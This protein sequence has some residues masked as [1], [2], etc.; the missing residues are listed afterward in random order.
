MSVQL[1]LIDN[2]T[3]AQPSSSLIWSQLPIQTRAELT[4]HFAQLLVR[5]ARPPVDEETTHDSL[6]DQTDSL[7]P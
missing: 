2:E 1:S 5:I 4:E 6:E 3:D 7:E